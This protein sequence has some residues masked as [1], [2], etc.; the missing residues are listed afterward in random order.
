MAR[1]RPDVP[2]ADVGGD[3]E[4]VRKALLRVRVV[5]RHV[6]VDEA[7]KGVDRI[8][9]GGRELAQ[10]PIAAARRVVEDHDRHPVRNFA[11]RHAAERRIHDVVRGWAVVLHAAFPGKAPREREK[12]G[13]PVRVSVRSSGFEEETA[14][15][16]VRRLV[17]VEVI[18]VEPEA[19]V[20]I[21]AHRVRR[22]P[23]EA[24]VVDVSIEGPGDRLEQ[25][26]FGSG[27]EEMLWLRRGRL[28]PLHRRGSV[29]VRIDRRRRRRSSGRRETSKTR[30]RIPIRAAGPGS[31]AH[32]AAGSASPITAAMK[33]R[34]LSTLCGKARLMPCEGFLTPSRLRARPRQDSPGQRGQRLCARPLN[35]PRR[36]APAALPSLRRAAS[37]SA[38]SAR[39]RR[40]SLRPRR[41]RGA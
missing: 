5:A 21:V 19:P 13:L 22:D 3:A 10:E 16:G 23:G 7:R 18:A 33:R 24:R 36:P 25:N 4:A 38:G 34:K 32:S 11:A 8:D 1:A 14:V 40:R 17:D 41:R 27:R 6:A 37:R 15:V 28:V 30:S 26:D 9:D 20:E 31:C 29:R 35:P 12:A 2:V 39:P